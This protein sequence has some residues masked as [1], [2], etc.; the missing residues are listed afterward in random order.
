MNGLEGDVKQLTANTIPFCVVIKL[1]G[2][3]GH[4]SFTFSDKLS[5]RIG[6]YASVEIVG[7]VSVRVVNQAAADKAPTVRVACIPTTELSPPIRP[8]HVACIGGSLLLRDSVYST[9]RKS[10]V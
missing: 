8:E 5:H 10:V 9:D 3:T 7:P 6:H 1:S 4:G 2:T